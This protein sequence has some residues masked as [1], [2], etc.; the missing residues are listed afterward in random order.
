MVGPIGD[1][2]GTY[3]AARA[4]A[5]AAS[6][7]RGNDAT[8]VDTGLCIAITGRSA[9]L[10]GGALPRAASSGFGPADVTE[11]GAAA[12]AGVKA[13]P[14]RE[15]GGIQPQRPLIVAQWP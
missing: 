6:T 11:A 10:L 9:T 12:R 1:G 14:P 13:I 2:I 3:S 5:G 8:A 4:G 15:E 7:T